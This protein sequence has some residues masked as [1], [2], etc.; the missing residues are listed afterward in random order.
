MNEIAFLDKT[1]KRGACSECIPELTKLNHE[2]MPINATIFEI[3]D[4][5]M[6][7]E[8]NMLDLLRQR[9]AMLNEN[10]NKMHIIDTDQQQFVQEQQ[11]KIN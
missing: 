3:R 4:V 6:N 9:T 2:L 10:K 7:L 5:M 11:N 1:T 8:C